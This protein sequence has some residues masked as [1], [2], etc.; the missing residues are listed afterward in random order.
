M[1]E[2]RGARAGDFAVIVP[3]SQLDGQLVVGAF[4]EGDYFFG[5]HRSALDLEASD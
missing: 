5:V 2:R 4:L 1:F 3:S